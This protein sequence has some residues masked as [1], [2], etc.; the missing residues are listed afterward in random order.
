[1]GTLKDQYPGNSSGL[2]NVLAKISDT[3][4]DFQSYHLEFVSEGGEEGKMGRERKEV[5]GKGWK[6]RREGDSGTK[7]GEGEK[8][9]SVGT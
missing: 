7:E 5:A 6:R 4:C 3:I 2:E 8:G 1:L 9:G